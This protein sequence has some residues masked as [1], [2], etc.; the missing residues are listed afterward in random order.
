VLFALLWYWELAIL[1][2]MHLAPGLLL[3]LPLC[4]RLLPH[5]LL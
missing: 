4:S 2:P 1:P 3:R 5:Q